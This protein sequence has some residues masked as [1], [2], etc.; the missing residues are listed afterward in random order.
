MHMNF[1]RPFGD[2]QSRGNF[3]VAHIGGDQPKDLKFAAGQL[4]FGPRN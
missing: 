1:Y 3:H 2:K 4:D